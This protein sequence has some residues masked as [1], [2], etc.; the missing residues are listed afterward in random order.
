MKIDKAIELLET[1][2]EGFPLGN[3][4]QYFVAMELGIEALKAIKNY[5]QLPAYST[6][7]IL[8]GETPPS[9]PEP[10]TIHVPFPLE[11]GTSDD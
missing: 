11:R 8:P 2:K 6:L 10:F 4:E 7:R 9:P 1:A 5:R 3:V